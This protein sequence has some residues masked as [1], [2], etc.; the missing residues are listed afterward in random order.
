MNNFLLISAALLIISCSGPTEDE[1]IADETN[2]SEWLAYGRTHSEQRFSPIADIDTSAVKGL[3]VDWYLDLPR[4]AGL[5]STPLVVDGVL[6]FTGTMNRVRAVDAING[7]LLWSFDPEVAKHLGKTRKPGWTQSRGLSYYAGK[8]FTAT[9]EGRLIALD[10]KTGKELWS[11]LTIDPDKQMSIT[12]APKAFAGKVLIGNGGSEAAPNRGYV[13]AYDTE[14]GKLVWRFYIVPGNPDD[15]F[16]N[17]AMAM[18]AKT[19]TGEWWRYGGGGNS[20]HGFTYD[21]EL[22]TLYIGTGNG[23]PWNPKVR[24]ENGGDNLFLSS[25]IALNPDNGG[26]KWHYQTSPGDAWDYNSNMDIV[27]AALDIKGVKTKVLMHAP[28]NGFFYV[29]NRETG[30]LISAKPFVETTWATSIDSITGRPNIPPGARYEN[31]PAYITPSPHGAHSWH[32]MSFNPTTGLVYIPAIHDAVIFDDSRTNLKSWKDNPS[33]GGIAVGLSDPDSLPRPYTGSLEAWD[34]VKQKLRWIVPLKELW[35]AGTLTTAGNLVFQGTADG[36]FNA[37]NAWTGK[38]LWS[39]NAGLGISAPPIT[40]KING[41]Q[42]IALLVGWGG[43]FAGVGNKVL[44]WEYN[45]HIRRLLV[46]SLDGKAIVPPQPP[47]YFAKPLVD[48]TFII[49]DSKVRAGFEL[50]FKCT[51]CHGAGAVAKG[52]AP[53]LRASPIPLSSDVFTDVVRNGAKAEMGMPAFGDL[54]DDQLE[55]MR[56][57]IRRRAHEDAAQT[58]V[59]SERAAEN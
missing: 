25:I 43:A 31:G 49:D 8:I 26:Y 51:G 36:M 37:Y 34:P 24:S 14:T 55:A 35:N 13:T 20:W 23:G 22:H 18:A 4:D 5:V 10:A 28:K 1:K 59:E 32:A 45:R 52:M 19:W 16:E 33:K 54:T 58:K 46:F 44:G 50:F 53:D 29:I 27:L 3:K 12:G 42:Y 9:W 30:K 57:F 17:D 48:K 47:P 6:Y 21:K 11:V 15:G 38:L 40:Y 39:Y 41:R 56:H 7:K 2:T